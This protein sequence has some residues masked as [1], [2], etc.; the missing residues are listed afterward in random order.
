M[1]KRRNYRI[2]EDDD[3]IL[4]SGYRKV[5]NHAILAG[6][7]KPGEMGIIEVQHDDWC[8]IF[9]GGECNCNPDIIQRPMPK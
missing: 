2:I 3:P 8:G 7:L 9:K 4:Q 1:K 6:M 5:I